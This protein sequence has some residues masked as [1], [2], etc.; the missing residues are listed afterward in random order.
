VSRSCGLLLYRLAPAPSVW[1]GHMGGPF[2]STKDAGAWS[3]PKGEPLD[4]EGD[5]DAALREFAEEIGAAA[6]EADYLHLGDFR[7][8]SGKVV[9]VFAGRAD[10]MAFVASNTFELEWP[11]RSG[12]I[13][14]FPELDGA[15]WFGLD[16]ARE[17]VVKGQRAMIDAI[18]E[19]LEGELP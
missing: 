10:D 12:R 13:Q 11:P 5:L 15:R 17:R 16:D 7:Q 1:L 14:N 8:S 6:P 18:A 9:T 19:R 2:W 4:G 3:V